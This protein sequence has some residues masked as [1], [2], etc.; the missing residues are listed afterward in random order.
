MVIGLLALT[1]IPT[2]TGV[3]FAVQEQR[4]ANAATNDEKLLRKFNLSCWCEG[5]GKASKQV[6]G[7]KVVLGEGKVCF[8]Y[9]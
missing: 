5:Q 9:T 7:G 1:G 6:H 2:T 3:A 8:V 4:R